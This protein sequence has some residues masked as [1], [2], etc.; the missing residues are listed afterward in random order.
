MN[1]DIVKRQPAVETSSNE[2]RTVLRL[3]RLASQALALRV[4]E[5]MSP[6]LSSIPFKIGLMKLERSLMALSQ[7]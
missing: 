1:T 7:V 5:Q 4:K 3:S 6:V 2:E